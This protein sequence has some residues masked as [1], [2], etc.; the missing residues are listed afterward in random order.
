MFFSEETSNLTRNCNRDFSVVSVAALNRRFT[1]VK[2]KLL[3]IAAVAVAATPASSAA[4]FA[5]DTTTTTTTHTET[6]PGPGVYVG[7]PGVA[8]VHVGAP[9]VS[10]GTSSSAGTSGHAAKARNVRA[11]IRLDLDALNRQRQGFGVTSVNAIGA[12]VASNFSNCESKAPRRAC[13]I[14]RGLETCSAAR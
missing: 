6:A 5:D 9:P 8:G 3:R 1:E 12:P 11:P 4:S 2:M 10:D 13:S 14:L 7:V